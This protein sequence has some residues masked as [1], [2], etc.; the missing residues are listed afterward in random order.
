MSLGEYDFWV[1]DENEGEFIKKQWNPPKDHPAYDAEFLE[2]F[3]IDHPTKG[4]YFLFAGGNGTPGD[5]RTW[6]VNSRSI[7]PPDYGE[8][9]VYGVWDPETNEEWAFGSREEEKHFMNKV[10][11][12]LSEWVDERE[13]DREAER[14]DYLADM[15]YDRLFE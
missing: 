8:I 14:A 9:E 7:D 12:R 11:D 3:S 4:E 5:K 10:R 15:A 1:G 2:T 6:N 13:V